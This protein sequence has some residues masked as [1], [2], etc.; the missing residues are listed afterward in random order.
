MQI[1]PTT[2]N[3]NTTQNDGVFA[4][5]PEYNKLVD[6]PADPVSGKI[7]WESPKLKD[8]GSNYTAWAADMDDMIKANRLSPY[9]DEAFCHM[10]VHY[11]NSTPHTDR[12]N[13]LYIT[14]NGRMLY[15]KQ[16]IKNGL[17]E[18]WYMLWIVASTYSNKRGA[19]ASWSKYQC[20]AI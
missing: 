9:L 11:N 1:D 6:M 8:D 2:P 14:H 19:L 13:N 10:I 7:R 3:Q 12:V 5:F 17:G 15:L 20:Q 4:R 16:M 18:E